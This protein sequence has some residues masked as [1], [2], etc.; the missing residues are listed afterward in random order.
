MSTEST[1]SPIGSADQQ[2]WW[3]GTQW[4]PNVAP[5]AAAAPQ[6]D[7]TMALGAGITGLVS[8]FGLIVPFFWFLAVPGSLTALIMG[9]VS[10]G[11]P[12]RRGWATTAVITG[13]LGLILGTIMMIS[14]AAAFMELSD[15]LSS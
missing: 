15:S 7:N 11:R 3:D 9:W 6:R 1:M 2:W 5:H 12:G 10:W 8:L 14:V 13:A 4:V